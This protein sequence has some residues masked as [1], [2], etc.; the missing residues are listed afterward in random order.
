M[1][2]IA[3]IAGEA[4]NT[5]RELFSLVNTDRA[6]VLAEPTSSMTAAR[7]FEVLPNHPVVTV[8]LAMKL[9]KTTRPTA[10]KAVGSLVNA[11]VLI[12]GSGKKRD[13]AFHYA[14]Y[15]NVLGTETEL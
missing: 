13:R 8:A 11:G 15:L 2:A 12:E 5:A 4:V 3:V 1:E 9:L 7:L 6:K 10:A 14:G